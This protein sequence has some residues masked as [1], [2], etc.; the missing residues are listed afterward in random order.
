MELM[1]DVTCGDWLLERVGGRGR[2]GGVVGTG[3]EAYTRILHPVPATRVDLSVTGEW[4]EHPVL[5]ESRW[6]WSQAA[7]RQGLTMHP[8]V[9][10]NRIADLDRGVD[11]ADCWQL[12]QTREGYFDLDL[13]AALTEQLAPATTTPEDLVAGIWNGWGELTGSGRALYAIE[14]SRL[15]AWLTRRQVLREAERQQQ[16]SLR[17]EIRAAAEHGPHLEWP[18]RE[19]ILCATSC[20]ELS[21][22]SW[23]EGAGLGLQPG[24][25]PSISPQLLWPADRSWVVASEIDWDSTIVAGSRS[26]LDAVLG[27]DRLE[28]YE[29]DEDSD[30]SWEGDL[31]NPPRAGW[32][33]GS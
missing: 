5:E 30:L 31:V 33:A 3:F 26:L 8:L 2:V 32:S 17:P 20:D 6:T 16:Q 25:P 18:A 29:V 23:A 15:R 27:D 11:F 9:Q 22:P 10:W 21:D 14:G 4:G 13:L 19:M 1:T 12:G 7:A 24:F 28:A